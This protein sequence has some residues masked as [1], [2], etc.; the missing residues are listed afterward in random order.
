MDVAAKQL[1]ATMLIYFCMNKVIFF[2]LKLVEIIRSIKL[3]N[4]KP[5]KFKFCSVQIPFSICKQQLVHDNDKL[6][7]KYLFFHV[8]LRSVI[9]FSLGLVSEIILN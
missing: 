8:E 5:R 7:F 3:V 2:H 9:I 1:L 6:I 4:C